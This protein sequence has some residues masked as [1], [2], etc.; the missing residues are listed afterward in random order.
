MLL[1]GSQKGG[2]GKT[3]IAVNLAIM[4][5]HTGRNVIVVDTD[6]QA[7]AW[8]WLSVREDRDVEPRLECRQ[9]FGR[10]VDEELPDLARE[11]DD[12][13]VDVSGDGME[14]RAAMLHSDHMCIPIRASQVDV[15]TLGHMDQLVSELRRI[16]P[17]FRADILI[18]AAPSRGNEVAQAKAVAAQFANLTMLGT[19]IHDRA[20][21]REAA[22]QGCAITELHGVDRRAA[23]EIQ[24]LYGELFD[25]VQTHDVSQTA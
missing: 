2:V 13:V 1:V 21:Y 7:S 18:N 11:F 17:A 5:A 4:R 24:A 22:M 6:V 14:L 16:K 20:A 15:W 3:T 8:N 10:V 12:V 19:V 23:Q 9:L 25:G